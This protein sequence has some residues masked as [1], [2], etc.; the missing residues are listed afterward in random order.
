MD[1]I[2]R[3]TNKQSSAR[4]S[5]ERKILGA[6]F[7]ISLFFI[8]WKRC[9]RIPILV[10]RVKGEFAT[11]NRFRFVDAFSCRLV[12]RSV[13]CEGRRR[14][15]KR[16]DGN[17]HFEA[18]RFKRDEMSLMARASF[19]ESCRNRFQAERFGALHA[20][21]ST[22]GSVGYEAFSRKIGAKGTLRNAYA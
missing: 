1:P 18:S 2:G 22:D 3:K 13:R 6:N 10:S 7:V 17:L 8:R 16:S 12:H 5:R 15:R 19:D 20:S 11:R 21:G 4:A 14:S 9:H